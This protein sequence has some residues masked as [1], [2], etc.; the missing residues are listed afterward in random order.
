MTRFS[1]REQPLLA[2]RI[3]FRAA[4][5]RS[6]FTAVHPAAESGFRPLPSSRPDAMAAEL[7]AGAFGLECSCSKQPPLV[8]AAPPTAQ[9]Q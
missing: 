8:A 4:A 9:L 3:A 2:A 6:S 7:G 5:T 1:P